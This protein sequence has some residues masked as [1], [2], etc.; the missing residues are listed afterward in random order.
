MILKINGNINRYYV[1][2]LC[3]VFFPGAT[4][5]ENEEPGEGIPEVYLTL[6]NDTEGNYTATASIKLNDKV[7][8]ADAFVSKDDELHISSV[9]F[10]YKIS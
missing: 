5:G 8:V 9:Y 6:K 1:Q 2:T 10:A 3:M 7:C 4:F